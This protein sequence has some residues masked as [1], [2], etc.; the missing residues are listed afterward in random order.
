MER[1]IFWV[2]GLNKSEVCT[3]YTMRNSR[4]VHTIIIDED[5]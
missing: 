4:V 3:I 5:C 2:S 1:V